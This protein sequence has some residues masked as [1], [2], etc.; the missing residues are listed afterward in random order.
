[1][2]DCLAVVTGTTSGIGEA[3]ARQL[4]ERG[5]RVVG[6]ARRE[7]TLRHE[8]YGH[9]AVDSSAMSSRD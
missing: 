4:L 3:V 1:M 6:I 2:S 8:R 5:W 9:V 7:A